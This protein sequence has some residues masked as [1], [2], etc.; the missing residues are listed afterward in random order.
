VPSVYST[1]DTEDDRLFQHDDNDSVKGTS[2]GVEPRDLPERSPELVS[3]AKCT[4]CDLD[5]RPGHSS[6]SGADRYEGH[7]EKHNSSLAGGR[8]A[9]TQL[10]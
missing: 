1:L 6:H 2:D 8:R 4:P 10:G 9:H 7:D 3:P 5:A